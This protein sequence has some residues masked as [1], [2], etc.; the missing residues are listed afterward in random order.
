MKKII[1]AFIL[2]VFL[3]QSVTTYGQEL[4]LP[5]REI[6][7]TY[8]SDLDIDQLIEELPEDASLEVPYLWL[9]NR[10][11][12]IVEP[13]DITLA[14]TGG[15]IPYSDEIVEPF[16]ALITAAEL[17][18][19][20]LYAVSGYR[21]VAQQAAN[22]EA[23]LNLNMSD[24]LDYDTAYYYT[25]MFVAPAD[26]SEHSTGLAIDLLG[27][28][29]DQY[30]GDLHQAYGQYPSAIWLAEES[31]AYGFVVRYLDGKQDITGYEYEPWHFRYV[32]V[33]HAEFMNEYDL[34]LEEYLALIQMRDESK[35]E[36][37]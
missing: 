17:D 16:E 8:N 13:T 34:V 10:D 7:E 9:V 23:R 2:T 6:L 25:D 21:S 5:D 19:H 3:L 24:G 33:E 36:T 14:Y 1:T 35:S 4:I 12:R 37:E 15:G 28:D 31:D 30:G 32:G 27:Y 29:W 11:N 26:A 20:Y 18:G 22:F